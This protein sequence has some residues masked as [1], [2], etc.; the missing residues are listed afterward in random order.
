MNKYFKEKLVALGFKETVE[1]LFSMVTDIKVTGELLT[2]KGDKTYSRSLRK[3]RGD[4][5]IIIFYT[6][7]C[8]ICDAEKKAARGIFSEGKS[9]KKTKVLMVNV[10][11]IIRQN[12]GMASRLFDSFDLSSLPFIFET[13]RKGYIQRR[14]ITLVTQ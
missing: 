12:P 5:N 14:Y 7:G 1:D 13:D 3:L 9:T 6:E 8:N 4:R 2:V 11:Q 10:D